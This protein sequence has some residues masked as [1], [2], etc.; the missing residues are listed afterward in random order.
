V[1]GHEAEFGVL[2]HPYGQSR[3]QSQARQYYLDMLR[4]SASL[5]ATWMM[6]ESLAG[7]LA[8]EGQ[9]LRAG[10]SVGLLAASPHA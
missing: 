5:N 2:K 8:R 9:Y 10:Q 3:V 7:L 6:L 1:V 4:E